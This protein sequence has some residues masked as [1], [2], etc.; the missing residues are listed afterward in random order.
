MDTGVAPR[1]LPW[2]EGF[3]YNK[4]YFFSILINVGLKLFVIKKNVIISQTK[5][6]S[7]NIS[8]STRRVKT[9]LSLIMTE[10]HARYIFAYLK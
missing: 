7:I 2:P 3:P 6:Y 9:W 5:V 1:T 8:F 10:D 4:N